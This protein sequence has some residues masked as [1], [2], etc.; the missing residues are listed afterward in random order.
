MLHSLRDR[1]GSVSSAQLA[2]QLPMLLRGLFYEGWHP[3]DPPSKVRHREEFLARVRSELSQG[4]NI[5]AETA[6]EAVFST[7]QRRIDPGEVHKLQKLL[8]EELR[9]LWPL[10]A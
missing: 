3:A 2:A 6:V 4:T 5:S 10:P 7:I 9:A 8:P 1:V